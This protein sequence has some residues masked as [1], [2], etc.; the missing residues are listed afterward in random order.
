[1]GTAAVF[2]Y[3]GT[4]GG[5]GLARQAF[6][7][8]EIM[9][10]RTFDAIR[11]CKC[12]NGCPAC[13]HSPK[14]GSGNRPIDK[15]TALEI[16]LALK[17]GKSATPVDQTRIDPMENHQTELRFAQENPPRAGKLNDPANDPASASFHGL[18]RHPLTGVKRFGVLDIE[19]RRSAQE[20]GGWG[21]AH[22]M[23]VSCAVL[24]DSGIN[25]FRVY[26]EAD[27]GTLVQDLQAFDLVIGFNIKGFDYK[28]LSGLV[29]FDLTT[30]PT[31]DM[32][33][34]VHERL[35]YRL[36]L[37]ALARCT[38]GTSKSADGLAA[39]EWWKQGEIH[40]IIEY[41]K[42]DVKVTRDLYLFGREHGFLVFEN[43][44]KKEVCLPVAW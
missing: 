21:R 18:P 35:G 7:R 4:P 26:L 19:T 42:Q 44:A 12:D 34:K 14:C 5:I 11:L 23:G 24:F 40:R 29:S 20:V 10:A 16:L 41:C 37:D 3:D 25:D 6:E 1:V 13:V 38:L 17:K 32:L 15:G 39:L 22:L 27:V 28:V 9:L 36:S 43:K 33:V 30:I 2:V 8:A 31:L